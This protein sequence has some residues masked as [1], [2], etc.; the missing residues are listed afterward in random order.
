MAHFYL[1]LPSNSSEKY[2]DNTLTRFTTKLTKPIQLQG[3]WEVGLEELIFP[4]TW[5][6]LPKS[7]IPNLKFRCSSNLKPVPVPKPQVNTLAV[8]VKGG[9]Y[10]TAEELCEQAN[11]QIS[12]DLTDGQHSWSVYNIPESQYPKFFYRPI[13]KRVVLTL[14]SPNIDV[15]ISEPLA[16][17]MGFS[18]KDM[19]LMP[20]DE[21]NVIK[22]NKTVDLSGGI[23]A[24]FVYCDVVAC[25]PVG[26]SHVPLLRIVEVGGNYGETLH[27]LYS[28]PRY[29][30]VQKKDFDSIEIDIR[31]DLGQNIP[32]EH[33][34]LIATLHFRQTKAEYMR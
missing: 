12:K 23:H 25:V 1:T 31:D 27:R 17:M 15:H 5:F 24:L 32:F 26:D 34:K 6:N 16:T 4:K 30:P 3:D 33:G 21:G 11:K 20:R 8:N 14:T 9:H 10:D 18:S 7:N 29:V 13:S 22:S 19:P 28:K 2:Y